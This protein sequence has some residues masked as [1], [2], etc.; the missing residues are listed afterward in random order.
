MV[1]IN[2]K[3]DFKSSFGISRG[4]VLK[5]MD[6]KVPK[7]PSLSAPVGGPCDTVVLIEKN[8]HVSGPAEFK[9]VL[10]KGQL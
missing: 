7:W 2:L 4:L 8:L 5:S 6:A 3:E 10:L 9:P 1:K